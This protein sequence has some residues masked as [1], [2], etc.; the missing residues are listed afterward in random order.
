MDNNTSKFLIPAAVVLAGLFIGGA[1]VWNGSHPAAGGTGSAG[2]AQAVNIKDVK[3]DGEPYYGD[4]NAPVTIAYWSDYQC[5]FC[6]QFET[7]T[8][9]QIIQNYVSQGKVKIV[10]KDFQFLG[11]DSM[12]DAEWARAVWALYPDQFFAWRT[13]IYN[14]QPEENSLSAADNLAWLEQTTGGV[15]GVDVS[16]IEAAVKANQSAYDAA[17]NADKAE[18][19]TFGVSA[20]PSFI[21]GTQLIA[22]AYPY[23]NFDSAIQAAM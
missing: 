11:P 8:L 3:T 20:T 2:G 15:S 23:A 14:A 5:P 7:Q 17:I 21:I 18:A 1:V 16:K 6:K 13:A 19:G 10:F 22:G 4:A 12:A 9:P